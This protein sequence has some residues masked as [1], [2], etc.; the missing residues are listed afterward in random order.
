MG[1]FFTG[2]TTPESE[3]ESAP[4]TSG[5]YDNMLAGLEPDTTDEVFTKAASI[6][7]EG[8]NAPAGQ[9]STPEATPW[10]SVEDRADAIT[11]AYNTFQSD[12][13]AQVDKAID[14]TVAEY[15]LDPKGTIRKEYAL[16]EEAQQARLNFDHIVAMRESD[17][18]AAIADAEAIQ[19][20]TERERAL[21]DIRLKKLSDERRRSS[22][23]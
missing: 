14:R 19:D 18:A 12:V 13:E 2:S 9:S 17:E 7:S 11:R 16:L 22:R 23:A 15:Q 6:A 4:D 3:G 8:L 21:R 5:P 10:V 20:P 1:E